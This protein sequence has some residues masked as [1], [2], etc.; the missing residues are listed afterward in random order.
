[1]AAAAACVVTVAGG[2]LFIGAVPA[3][4]ANASSSYTCNLTGIVPQTQA[5]AL[6][7]S[8]PDSAPA[9]STIQVSF[10]QPSG[11]TTAPVAITSITISGTA[12]VTNG[13][14]ST[15]PF[16]GAIGAVAAGAVIPEVTASASLTLPASTGSVGVVL[17]AT[18]NLSIVLAGLGTESGPC[19]T[20]STAG[21]LIAAQNQPTVTVSSISGQTGTTS[22]RPGSTV[23]FSGTG[24][25]A[26]A[27]VAVSLVSSTGGTSTSLTTSPATL[28]ATGGAISGSATIPSS[29]AAGVYAL[30]FSDNGG[31][32]PTALPLTILDTASCTANPAGG[33]AGTVATVSCSNFD[34]GAVV[35][36]QGVTSSGTATSDAAVSATANSSGAL[37]ASYTVNDGRT[38]G[39]KATEATPESLSAV[40]PFAASANSC[41]AD[42]GGATGGS[43][44]ISQGT[45]TTVNPGPLAMRQTAAQITLSNITL[46]GTPQTVTGSMNQITVADLRGSTIGWTLNATAT[47]FTG[48]TGGSIPA[49]SLTITPA[50]GP[51]TAGLAGAGT[52]SFPSTVT[53]GPSAAMGTAV[54]LC[55]TP[56]LPAGQVTGGVFDVTGNLSLALPAY[57]LSGTYTNTI[58]FSLG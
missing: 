1:M 23:T 14:V 47:Q 38:T 33:G 24:F 9:G 3:L 22:A 5:G 32:L 41:I 56:A 53:A 46:N 45:T 50:C 15:L 43:C 49:S 29:V 2:G 42:Q 52:T 21:I 7:V 20:S 4:A 58:T 28:T 19:T 11:G 36:V 40:A 31:D 17:P 51:D 44:S 12:T 18:Y 25:A 6:T 35:S 55:S 57:L 34:P 13:N 27:T 16:S 10:S 30:T 37:S 8:A 26:G 48:S 39:I 54:A